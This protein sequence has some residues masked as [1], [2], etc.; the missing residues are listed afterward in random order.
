MRTHNPPNRGKL[1][2]RVVDAAKPAKARYMLWDTVTPGF[3]LSV[4][5]GGAKSFILRYRP[6]RTGRLAPKRFVTIGRLGPLTAEEARQRAIA[7][8]GE[9]AK[10]SDPA[11]EASA[12]RETMTLATAAR[13][14]LITHVRAKRK[15]T[16]QAFYDHAVENKI[17][18]VLGRRKLLDVSSADVARLHHSI[19]AVPY[20]A[21]RVVAVLGSLYSWAGQR[22]LVPEN[23]NPTRRLEKFRESR[24]ERYL[25]S[26]ELLR[27]GEALREA[28]TTG[29]PWT[30]DESRLTSKHAPKPD[31]RYT[32][33]SPQAVAAIRLLIFT[34]CR[35]REILDLR[36]EHVDFE[37]GV[38]FLPDS[39]TGRKIVMLGAP[40]LQ[41]LSRLPRVG[42]YVI[43]GSSP[44]WP[45]T[46][47]KRPW[48]VIQRR[49]GLDGVRVHDLRHSYASVGAGIGLGLPIIGRLLGHAQPS[50]TARYAHLADDPL[51]RASEKIA[52]SIA[53]AMGEQ[54]APERRT[55]VPAMRKQS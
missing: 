9:V 23:F 21:N 31:K 36:W 25:T 1:T 28:E 33:I 15:P 43:A 13:E 5:V 41:V 42:A 50:T 12:E 39:K 18:P 14:F 37:R 17:L 47:L 3:G 44:E 35:R 46:D 26:D 53:D 48:S 49:A 40:A 45:R 30:V 2:K 54:P 16:T 7:I 11:A 55:V 29:I 52:R 34:G 8:L 24:R 19:R 32:M 22:G 6:G 51:R 27:L 20:M 38:L 4:A 10:G